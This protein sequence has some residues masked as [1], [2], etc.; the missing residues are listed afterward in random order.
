LRYDGPDAV[1]V[2]RVFRWHS[3]YDGLK[4]DDMKRLK[5]L[6]ILQEAEAL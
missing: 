6:E 1:D 4:A 3:Q 2:L 5:D